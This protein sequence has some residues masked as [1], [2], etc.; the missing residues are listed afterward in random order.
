MAGLLPPTITDA[1]P[2]LPLKEV[3]AIV[4]A[5]PT[6]PL[7]EKRSIIERLVAVHPTLNVKQES[8]WAF[9]RCRPYRAEKCRRTS[10]T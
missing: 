1:H 2:P 6:M 4:E 8:G 7:A 5:F 10:M 3:A 9:R